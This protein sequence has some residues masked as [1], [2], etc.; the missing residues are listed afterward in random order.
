MIIILRTLLSNKEDCILAKLRY[1]A[2][3]TP[4]FW[5]L[6]CNFDLVRIQNICVSSSHTQIN[7]I[8][9][10]LLFKIL[11][12][13]IVDSSKMSLFYE[14]YSRKEDCLYGS[15]VRKTCQKKL[16][17]PRPERIQYTNRIILSEK[18]SPS[19]NANISIN[20]PYSWKEHII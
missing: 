19:Q 5:I 2:N 14:P 10:T 4:K 11:S 15:K 17:T 8:I 1:K 16:T 6:N 18:K 3:P 20:E 9:R 7:L 13:K 12:S